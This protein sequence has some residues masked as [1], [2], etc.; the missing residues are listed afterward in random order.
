MAST[1]DWALDYNCWRLAPFFFLLA[2]LFFS[3]QF[4]IPFFLICPSYL[5]A[6]SNLLLAQ[7]A[8]PAIF[9]PPSFSS[10][11]FLNNFPYALDSI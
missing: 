4:I 8:S 7:L 6:F 5:A 9:L 11:L 3:L 1:P 10:R 2:A